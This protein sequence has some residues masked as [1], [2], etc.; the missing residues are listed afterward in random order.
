MLGHR[1]KV[2]DEIAN[3]L[4]SASISND[5]YNLFISLFQKNLGITDSILEN[6]IISKLRD[7]KQ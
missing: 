3:C 1:D 7:I 5:K 6:I 2:N 4:L